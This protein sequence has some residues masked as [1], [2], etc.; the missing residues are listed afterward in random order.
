MNLAMTAIKIVNAIN[1]ATTAA[2]INVT[3]VTD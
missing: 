2:T 3:A 1:A